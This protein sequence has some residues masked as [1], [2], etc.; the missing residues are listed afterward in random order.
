MVLSSSSNLIIERMILTN[1]QKIS[2]GIEDDRR[3]GQP[4]AGTSR[5][6][7]SHRSDQPLPNLITECMTAQ[8]GEHPLNLFWAE[9]TP[10]RDKSSRDPVSGPC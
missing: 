3:S 1:Y 2:A 9:R 10:D 6:G 8:S 4:Q 7:Y 5:R